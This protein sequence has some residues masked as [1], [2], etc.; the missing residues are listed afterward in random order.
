MPLEPTQGSDEM[1]SEV[2][3]SVD[4]ADSRPKLIIADVSRDEAWVSVQ[5]ADA[6]V[7]TEWC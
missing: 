3:A 5:T 2:M 6:P 4:A 1:E 7:L